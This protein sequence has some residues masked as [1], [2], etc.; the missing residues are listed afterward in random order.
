MEAVVSS[1][2]DEFH[3]KRKTAT[4]IESIVALVV[5]VIVCMG[6]NI[7]YFDVKLPTGAHA[8]IL[9]VMDYISNNA[10]MPI[11][12]IGTC[13]LIGWVVKPK[14]VI[15]EVE[16]T[17]GSMGRKRLYTVMIRFVAPVLLIILFLKSAG[18]LRI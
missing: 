2:M 5:G 12:A 10:L 16:K 15:D 17:G 6:Y 18:L 3:V 9:D 13:I 7:L 14:V 1:I 8:Q 11:V 4:A